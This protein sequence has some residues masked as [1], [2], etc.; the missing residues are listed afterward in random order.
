MIEVIAEEPSFSLWD[1]LANVGGVIGLYAGMSLI[2]LLEVYI[3]RGELRIFGTLISINRNFFKS[4]FLCI[5]SE[6]P[7]VGNDVAAVIPRR[8]VRVHV[9][10]ASSSIPP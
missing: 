6:C 7:L 10:K 4:S 2:T 8:Q 1:F 3:N 5:Y 9:R